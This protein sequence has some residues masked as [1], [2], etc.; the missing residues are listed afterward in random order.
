MRFGDVDAVVNSASENRSARYVLAMYVHVVGRVDDNLA[1][2]SVQ[3]FLR[4][5]LAKILIVHYMQSCADLPAMVWCSNYSVVPCG[6]V[7]A[8]DLISR[9][10]VSAVRM[11]RGS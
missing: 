6:R 5:A 7:C 10:T 3:G 8:A 4:V 1:V 2:V 11:R 9:P